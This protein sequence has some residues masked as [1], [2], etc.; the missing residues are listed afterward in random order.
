LVPAISPLILVAAFFAGLVDATV[1]GGGLILVPALFAAYP[2]LPHPLLLGTN[3]LA[4]ACGT[5]NAYFAYARRVQIPFPLVIRV[6]LA[7]GFCAV[8][9]AQTARLISPQLF[10]PLLPLV[11]LVV[12]VYTVWKK[13][14]GAL[15]TFRPDQRPRIAW[16]LILG[17]GI[18]FYDG[19]IGPGT[20]T[21]L[22]LLFVRLFGF[23]FLH[24]SAAAKLVNL[25]TNLAALALFF[26]TQN[27][28][29]KLGLAL[30]L[31]NMFGGLIG[32]RLVI[33]HGNR[34]IRRIFLCVVIALLVKTTLDALR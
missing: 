19:L 32:A 17:A 8:L 25:A 31:A 29:L 14:L 24:G 16:A 27:V 1:G 4:A 5:G 22:I 20:G 33:L 30:G 12:L 15:H 28:L 34:L 18:G 2:G 3:K 23:D 6:A 10:R 13:E 7:A 21:F 9:G 26:G 11:L